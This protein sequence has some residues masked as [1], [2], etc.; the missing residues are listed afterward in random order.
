MNALSES[1]INLILGGL[2][3]AWG[4]LISIPLSLLLSSQMKREEQFYQHQ[5]DL[6]A[7]KQ[8][9][10]L[11]HKLEMEGK[12]KDDELVRLQARVAKLEELMGQ[13]KING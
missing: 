4:S 12:E 3:G 9:L 8:E 13:V 1:T 2:I 11:Q 7:K 5:L 6:V 10:L